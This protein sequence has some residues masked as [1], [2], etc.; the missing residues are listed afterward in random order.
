MQ[1]EKESKYK[2]VIAAAGFLIM[3]TVFSIINSVGTILITPITQANNFSI[4]Q[5]SF[6][7][8]INAITIAISAPIVGTLINKISIKIIMSVGSIIASVAYISYGFANTIIQ[9]YIIGV[10]VSIGL[11]CLTWVPIS[12]MVSDWFEPKKKGSVMGIVFSGIGTGTFFWMQIASRILEKS[13]YKFVYRFFGIIVL[14]V[15]LPISLF[16]VKRPSKSYV[17]DKEHAK[18]ETVNKKALNFS[19]ISKIKCF[20]PFSIGLLLLGISFGGIKQHYQTYLSVLGYPLRF[21]AN[22]GSLLAAIGVFANIIAGFLFDHYPTKKL[23]VGFEVV[24]LLSIGFLFFA[25]KPLCAYLF[26]VLYGMTMCIAS[27]WPSFGVT[28]IF[29][30]DNYSV[31]YGV[32]N[33]FNTIGGAIGPF[34]AGVIADSTFGYPLVWTIFLVVMFVCYWLFI[35]SVKQE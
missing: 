28:K 8:T 29:S 11:S 27:I 15:S 30:N 25:D 5:Y 12:T 35:R 20:W 4:S 18:E 17:R 22:I 24:T 32:A 14:A 9:F 1:M 2:Y 13:S 34:L 10:I 6:L 7:F 16:I 23:L 19:Q 33:M 26:T 21:S 3:G 31:V